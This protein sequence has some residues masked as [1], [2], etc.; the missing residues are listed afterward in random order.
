M[1]FWRTDSPLRP[2]LTARQAKKSVRAENRLGR[3]TLGLE[4]CEQRI[5]L[6]IDPLVLISVIPNQG[7]VITS[8]ETLNVAPTQITLNFPVGESIN[9]ATLSAITITRAGG[10]GIIG[11]SND[12]AITSAVVPN[13]T[14]STGFRG[15]GTTANEVVIRFDKDLPSDLYD[16]HIAGTGTTPLTDTN[17][18]IFNNG[19]DEDVQFTLDLGAQVASVVPQPVSRNTNGTLTQ[20]ANEIDV[21]FT[22]NTLTTTSAQNVANYELINTL[23]TA[24]NA[25]D[26]FVNPTSAVYNSATNM[27]KLTFAPGQ[28]SS[29]AT[30]RLRVGNNDPLPLTPTSVNVAANLATYPGDTLDTAYPLGTFGSGVATGTLQS[31]VATGAQITNA[32]ASGINNPG[33]VLDPGHRDIP[34][35]IEDSVPAGSGGEAIPEI[36]YGFP[37]IY[38]SDPISGD[39]LYNQITAQQEED[40]EAIFALY[41]KYLGVQFALDPSGG[42]I[43]VVTGDPRVLAP[44]LCPAPWAAS[45]AADW[46][47]SMP[48][49]IGAA[50]QVC[51]AA[52]G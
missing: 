47:L 21:Y 37:T 6:T 18:N 1:A 41:S 5:L 4:P 22:N 8:G 50:P 13:S 42:E 30:Y 2:S 31:V 34:L 17:G 7:A 48:S 45:K 3:R 14:D 33:N 43:N 52:P 11:N 44:R 36:T 9:A 28:V 35:A 24:T 27:V 19:A 29:A 40:A 23:N 51:T 20:N 10:D 16:I 25:D 32:S 46:R 49:I 12:V 38:G 15:L 39:P 26:T